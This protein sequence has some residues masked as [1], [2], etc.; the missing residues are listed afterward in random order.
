MRLRITRPAFA[1][2]LALVGV[3]LVARWAGPVPPVGYTVATADAVIP[4]DCGKV[5]VP[6][7]TPARI[8][9]SL[10][11]EQVNSVT[12]CRNPRKAASTTFSNVDAPSNGGVWDGPAVSLAQM[13]TLLDALATHDEL[14]PIPN[15]CTSEGVMPADPIYL[16]LTDGTVV[17][18]VIPADKCDRQLSAARE[19]IDTF[20]A[21]A[22]VSRSSHW[23]D[24]VDRRCPRCGSAVPPVT[25]LVGER[26][27]GLPGQGGVPATPGDLGDTADGG[28][29][30]EGLAG[31]VTRL[32]PDLG[33]GGG[34]PQ[35]SPTQRSDDEQSR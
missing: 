35:R 5:E 28:E 3:A 26:R 19:A 30:C 2:G 14:K 21:G 16:T 17:Q 1:V 6:N 27:T 13:Q 33:D 8:N 12:I 10:S 29:C 22:C 4:Y 18:P 9:A 7:L 25:S 34:L 24:P 32:D 23:S 31:A 20:P 11:V 15:S